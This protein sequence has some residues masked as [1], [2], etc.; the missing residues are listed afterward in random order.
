MTKY[1]KM[2]K[3]SFAIL[4]L[5]LILVAVLAFGGTYAYFTASA[6]ASDTITMGN[7]VLN[8]GT[9]ALTFDLTNDEVVPG[10]VIINETNKLTLKVT[11]NIKTMMLAEITAVTT[12]GT[13]VV[14]TFTEGAKWTPVTGATGYFAF[15]PSTDVFYTEENDAA[16]DL[17]TGLAI[18]RSN[19]NSI[20]NS[21]V[22]ITVNVWAM[23]YE[24]LDADETFTAGGATSAVEVYNAFKTYYTVGGAVDGPTL[25]DL[26]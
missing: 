25:A 20:M 26:A 22:T 16:L 18:D 8:D 14:L 17:I 5:S 12:S 2:K 3:S 1:S 11:T 24:Y 21:V 7:L 4:A 15:E 9:A 13:N 6:N 23:Q 19:G 10:Q